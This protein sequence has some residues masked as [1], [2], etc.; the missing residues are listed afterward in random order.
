[1]DHVCFLCLVL[2][3]LSL[4]FIAALW[5][6]AGRGLTSW[7]LLVMFIVF[8]LLSH[9]VSWVQVFY[10]DLFCAALFNPYTFVHV[11]LAIG[12]QCRSRSDAAKRGV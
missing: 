9:V 4:L 10:T 11:C 2:L 1:M 5:S 6:P 7:L 8:W 3:M 12:K